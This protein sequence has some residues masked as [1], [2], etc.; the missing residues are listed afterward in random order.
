MPKNSGNGKL[1]LFGEHSA[2][3]GY[4]AVGIP[5]PLFTEI[6]ENSNSGIILSEEYIRY[7]DSILALLKYAEKK[8]NI[9]IDGSFKNFTI[10]SSVPPESGLGSSAALCTALAKYL[11]NKNKLQRN[12]VNSIWKM[13]HQLEH[14]FHGTPSGIDTGLASIKQ[15]ASFYFKNMYLP[16]LVELPD[17]RFYLIYGTIPRIHSTR[18]LVDKIKLKRKET[19]DQTGSILADLGEITKYAISILSRTSFGQ[20]EEIGFLAKRAHSQ[21]Q[22]LD[23][24]TNLLDDI[25]GRAEQLGS[26]GGKLSGAGGGGAFWFVADSLEK[27]DMLI[28]E[29]IKEFRCPVWKISPGEQFTD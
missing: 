13:A 18:E 28:S 8:F 3:Y 27:S 10:S 14:Y 29:I 1:L 26:M 12:E 17:L 7:K 22:N 11:V 19:P 6:R 15:P 2:V 24:S 23:L 20:A 16:D 25:L 5:L 21:L 9:T 4:P